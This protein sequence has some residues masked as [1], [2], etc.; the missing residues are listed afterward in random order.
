[1]S[2]TEVLNSWFFP[3][4]VRRNGMI[5]PAPDEALKKYRDLREDW[6]KTHPD[7]P[8]EEPVI[9]LAPGENEGKEG[10][11]VRTEIMYK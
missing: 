10:Y 9:S 1:M 6:L 11:F 5:I 8:L 4:P 3:S 2:R 7:Y